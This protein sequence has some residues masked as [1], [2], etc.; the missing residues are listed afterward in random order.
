MTYTKLVSTHACM[1]AHTHYHMNISPSTCPHHNPLP[2]SASLIWS[3]SHD[4]S[5]SYDLSFDLSLTYDLSRSCDLSLVKDLSL[6]WDFLLWLLERE[7]L[8]LCPWLECRSCECL[9]LKYAII[10]SKSGHVCHAREKPI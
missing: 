3:G 7:R 5:L 1:H 4:Q 10:R 9:L 6:W 8:L 2:M